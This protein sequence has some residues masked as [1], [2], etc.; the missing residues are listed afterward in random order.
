MTRS[1]KIS[2]IWLSC[3][4]VIGSAGIG[5]VAKEKQYSFGYITEPG[6][7]LEYVGEVQTRVEVPWNQPNNVG[8]SQLF[9]RSRLETIAGDDSALIRQEKTTVTL[10]NGETINDEVTYRLLAA[11]FMYIAEPGSAVSGADFFPP[12]PVS[13]GAQWVIT[14]DVPVPGL[15]AVVPV[16]TEYT[17]EKVVDLGSD[18]VAVI[19]HLLEVAGAEIIYL[20]LPMQ[21]RMSGSGFSFWSLGT[22]D[23]VGRYVDSTIV[24]DLPE[25]M[26]E[27]EM[28]TTIRRS[29]TISDGNQ[30]PASIEQYLAV[31]L[32]FLGQ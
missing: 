27:G 26:G 30:L 20:D 1:V 9:Y 13:P 6:E 19:S 14:A 32:E 23:Y 16:R 25:A 8:E 24:L 15:G 2:L 29:E 3:L 4:V 21:L 5:A 12:G 31:C 28:V 7:V 22:G 11:D 17:L 10:P 18:Q